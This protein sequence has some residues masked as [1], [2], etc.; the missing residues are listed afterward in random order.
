MCAL[1]FLQFALEDADAA[2]RERTR[3][4]IERLRKR[5]EAAMHTRPRRH[6]IGPEAKP[7]A[8]PQS[9]E[10]KRHADSLT[11]PGVPRRDYHHSRLLSPY[12]LATVLTHAAVEAGRSDVA[13]V[14]LEATQGTKLDAGARVIV[15]VG[16]LPEQ[17]D[18]YDAQISIRSTFS[19]ARCTLA[20]SGR[21]G[22]YRL[23]VD[24][25]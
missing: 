24:G 17:L 9:V 7:L 2:G 11:T 18:R 25:M 4:R 3:R 20:T 8:L 23:E 21:G 13:L 15:R 1:Q 10:E 19:S 22:I 16:F 14:A 6:T 12:L 5:Q